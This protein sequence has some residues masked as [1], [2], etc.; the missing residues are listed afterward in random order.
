MS[1]ICAYCT[2]SNPDQ[3][4]VC[5]VCGKPLTRDIEFTDGLSRSNISQSSGNPA[6]QP[7]E[8]T[9]SFVPQ[10]PQAPRERSQSQP[11]DNMQSFVPQTPQ[12]PQVPM[13]Q[14]QAQQSSPPIVPMGTIST[15]LS[16]SKVHA[17]AGRG[18]LLT[19]QSWFLSEK[20]LAAA[21]MLT[22]SFDILRRRSIIGLNVEP[23]NL[24][25]YGAQ[26]ETRHYLLLRRGVATIF[27]Y[28]APAGHDLYIS[29]AT[30]VLTSIDGFRRFVLIAL[31]ALGILLFIVF[32]I[33]I[34][35]WL[36]LIIFFSLSFRNWLRERDFWIYL[37]KN[38]LNDF[39]LDDI[40]VMEQMTDDTLK[41]AAIQNEID[42]DKIMPPTKGYEH[43]RRIRAV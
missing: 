8:S 18:V 33:S 23:R 20:A 12:M 37:R 35:I 30:T 40:A 42:A 36:I 22:T 1:V 27:L 4:V 39:Q 13:R 34:P 10:A 7:S 11:D 31:I 9:L 25:D 6:S 41:A 43:G 28:I 21:N 2:H 24:Q 3:F 17:F 19:H 15:E 16:L 29:R 32:P 5:Q 38:E 26:T 14:M